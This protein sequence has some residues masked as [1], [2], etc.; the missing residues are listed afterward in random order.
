MHVSLYS[1]DTVLQAG[2]HSF[3]GR[4]CLH[5]QAIRDK[6]AKDRLIYVQSCMYR[7]ATV[8]SRSP[9]YVWD[10]SGDTVAPLQRIKAQVMIRAR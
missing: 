6:D 2:W 4:R 3:R 7:V 9:W 8:C 1:L 10:R 5:Y